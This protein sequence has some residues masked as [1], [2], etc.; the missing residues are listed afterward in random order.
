MYMYK[1]VSLVKKKYSNDFMVKF[2][3]M[4]LKCLETGI[5]NFKEK[6]IDC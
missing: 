4:G 6:S 2:M 5:I 1:L 3:L